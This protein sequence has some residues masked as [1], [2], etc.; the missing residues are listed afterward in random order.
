MIVGSEGDIYD[1]ARVTGSRV[2]EVRHRLADLDRE[3]LPGVEEAKQIQLDR[4]TTRD[5]LKWEDEFANAAIE[6]AGREERGGP[7]A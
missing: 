6:K 1:V 3:N 4:A 2:A 7:P 5:A